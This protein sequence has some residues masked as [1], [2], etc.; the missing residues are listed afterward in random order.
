MKYTIAIS[1]YKGKFIQECINSILKQSYTDF[2][3][4]ILNDESPD[5]IENILSEYNDPRIRYYKNDKNVGAVNLVDNWNKCLSLARGDYYMQMGDD[6]ILDIRY[7]ETFNELINKYPNLGVYHC[8]SLIIDENSQPYD[9]TSPL[10]EKES[11]YSYIYYRLKN[12]VQF[13][14]DF[15]YNTKLLRSNNGFYKLPL[16]WGSD[17]ITSYIA[18][19]LNGIAHTNE[20][21]FLYR[22]NRYSITSTGNTTIKIEAVIHII[23]WIKDYIKKDNNYNETA[24]L[25]KPLICKQLNKYQE[26]Q[27]THL[28]YLTLK[29]NK[30]KS[31]YLTVKKYKINIKLLLKAIIR[32]F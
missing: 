24:K 29:Q 12:R 25:F 30:I 4:I 14:S 27:I 5:N 10:P 16:A 32:F 11:I 21:V 26:E 23:Q 1:A 22:S 15:V 28:L 17:D 7:L 9:I 3:L 13:I 19:S 31:L 20:T 8:R 6:D 2:E 18:A